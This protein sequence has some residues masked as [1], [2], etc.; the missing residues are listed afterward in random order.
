MVVLSYLALVKFMYTEYAVAVLDRDP[1][2]V[3]DP[4]GSQILS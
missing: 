3:H 4:G 1:H 2:F